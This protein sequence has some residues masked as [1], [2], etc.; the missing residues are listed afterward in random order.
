[1]KRTLP[2]WMSKSGKNQICS[3]LPN[4]TLPNTCKL[5]YSH[6]V[7]DCSILCDELQSTLAPS[8]VIGFDIEW[9]VS[10]IKGKRD[11]TATIQI[12]PNKKQ[13][14]VFQV[15]K[16][17]MIPSPLKKLIEST[18]IKKTGVNVIGD[19]WKLHRD[20]NI[21]PDHSLMSQSYIELSHFA[22]STINSSQGWSLQR[23]CQYFLKSDLSKEKNIRSGD[24]ATFPLSEDQLYYAALDAYA[25]LLV[26]ESILS[27]K[28]ASAQFF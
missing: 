1:M 24:W 25:S 4:L 5:I 26:Y 23:L 18:E 12:C 7:N 6:D 19:M 10:Y 20:F 22:S 3:A 2:L 13:C 16:M 28:P 17:G 9:P 27:W 15:S 11:I 21:F 14:F 8:S